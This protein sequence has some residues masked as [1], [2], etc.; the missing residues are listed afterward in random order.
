MIGTNH[1]QGILLSARQSKH[2]NN[3]TVAVS[4]CSSDGQDQLIVALDVESRVQVSE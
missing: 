2:C 4:V 1:S 3:K